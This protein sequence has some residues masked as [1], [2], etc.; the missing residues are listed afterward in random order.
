MIE[1]GIPTIRNVTPSAER[2]NEAMRRRGRIERISIIA[3]MLN[4]AAHIEHFVA[5]VAAQDFT[6]DVE[7]I[8]ADGGSTDG[9]VELLQ[10]MARRARLELTLLSNP[11]RWVSQGL[12]AVHLSSDRRPLV[13]PRTATR[14]IRRTTC[15]SAPVPRRRPTHSW[16]AESSFQ[17]RTPTSA[18][19]PGDGQSVRR[20]RL[21]V[22]HG[23]G[24]RRE[25]DVDLR[26][27]PTGGFPR[28]GVFDES[29]VRNQDDEFTLRIRRAGGRVLLDPEIKVG[30]TPRGLT[31]GLP[32]VL[33]VR[34]LEG[35]RHAQAPPGAE[36]PQ[37]RATGL[38]GLPR[39]PCPRCGFVPVARAALLVELA[40][41]AFGG[42]VFGS[43]SLLNGSRFDSCRAW[44]PFTR[45]SHCLRAWTCLGTD[46]VF[47][48]ILIN[49]EN[50]LS[51]EELSVVL[52][53][54]G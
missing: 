54:L 29:L 20:D 8:V 48:S 41:Y 19:S 30:Y 35:A 45:L 31:G 34:V 50:R 18:P 33:P 53:K 36:R 38:L 24:E 28:A 44:S 37:P 51:Y 3:P 16:S 21:D 39:H 47:L 40:A 32:P 25:S 7:L 42:L 17:G 22:G 1:R 10:D 4:E 15:G 14:G 5:D 11:D 2:T 43:R 52:R 49:T 13:R 46:A 12:N 9:S 6:G 27:V 26:R 23:G